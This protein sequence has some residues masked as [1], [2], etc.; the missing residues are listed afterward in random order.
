MDV[1]Y[2]WVGDDKVDGRFVKLIDY[3]LPSESVAD[4]G[5]YLSEI[6]RINL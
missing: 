5:E 6:L 2:R 1:A 3:M 4:E